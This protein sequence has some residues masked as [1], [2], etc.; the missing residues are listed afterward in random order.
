MSEKEL[1]KA[2]LCHLNPRYTFDS[3]VV[4]PCNEFAYAVALEVAESQSATYNPILFYG[5]LGTGKTHLLQAIAHHIMEH[6]PEKKALYVSSELF[7]SELI[8][9]LQDSV[10]STGKLSAFKNKYR[11]VDILLIDDIQFIEGKEATQCEFFHTFNALHSDDKQIVLSS[12]RAPRSLRNLDERLTSRI[13]GNIVVELGLPDCETRIAILR[14]KAKQQGVELNDD[15]LEVIDL[16]A[17]KNCF[18]IRALESALNR[19]ILLAKYMRQKPTPE[20]VRE[21]LPDIVD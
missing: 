13:Q 8:R 2:E 19:T 4:G 18:D 10:D 16:I 7:T 11:N 15:F 17:G 14:S 20:F 1:N 5:G 9:A 21:N 12:D 6:Y 3:I